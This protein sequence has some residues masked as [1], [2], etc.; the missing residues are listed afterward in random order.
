MFFAPFILFTQLSFHLNLSWIPTK[1]KGIEEG[2]CPCGVMVKA[3]DCEIVV[4][5]LEFQLHNWIYF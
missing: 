3:L 5:E 1:R 2:E 4:S